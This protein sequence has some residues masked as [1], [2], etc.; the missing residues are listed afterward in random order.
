[1]EVPVKYLSFTSDFLEIDGKSSKAL[2][3][4]PIDFTFSAIIW[5]VIWTSGCSKLV[6][7]AKRTVKF[8]IGFFK[9]CESWIVTIKIEKIKKDG[10]RIG[11]QDK[12]F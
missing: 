1:M 6:K 12:V 3:L 4:L 8:S 11:Y 5:E 10:L 7:W 2:L 9:P